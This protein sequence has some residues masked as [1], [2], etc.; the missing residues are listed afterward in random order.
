MDQEIEP[1][2]LKEYL[3]IVVNME[4]NIYLQDR[5]ISQMRRRISEL[6]KL[7]DYQKPT[8]PKDET[9]KPFMGVIMGAGSAFAGLLLLLWGVGLCHGGIGEMLLGWI[10]VLFGAVICLGSIINAIWEVGESYKKIKSYTRAERA[11]DSAM[12]EY[13]RKTHADQIRVQKEMLEAEILS[14]ELKALEIQNGNS[15]E[16]LKKI[17]DLGIVFPKYRNLSMICSIY[18]YIDAKRCTSLGD[19]YNILEGEMR[20]D[21]I[22]MQM[23][24]IITQLNMVQKYQFMLYTVVQE[25]NEK[26][27][28]L[29]NSAKDMVSRMQ[30]IYAQSQQW[31]ERITAAERNT[32]LAAYQ[33][34]RIQAELHYMN[35][36]NYLTGKYR[37]IFFNTPPF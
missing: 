13:E 31:N 29:L 28:R 4:K 17:Y 23:D 6:G 27:D 34:Q 24:Q 2:D 33:A 35:R 1:N 9:G 11:Y 21:R 30:D 14:D 26:S 25:M 7:H 32:E 10:V 3:E 22:I 36:M 12:E 16:N 15:K 18:E 19:A 5:L 8:E 20:L 37:N